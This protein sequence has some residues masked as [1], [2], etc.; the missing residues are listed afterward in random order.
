MNSKVYIKQ[1]ATTYFRSETEKRFDERSLRPPCTTC[2]T[3]WPWSSCSS[4]RRPPGSWSGWQSSWSSTC[5]ST[6][7]SP[8]RTYWNRWPD[9][10]PTEL[11]RWI[12][13]TNWGNKSFLLL[14]R[15]RTSLVYKK[16]NNCRWTRMFCLDGPSTFP[17]MRTWRQPWRTIATKMEHPVD[18]SWPGNNHC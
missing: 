7:T 15:K 13:L 2:S 10:W 17:S 3:G 11:F 6:Q 5:P 16:L 14:Q 9:P 1:N 18:S 4:W 12:S 8:T